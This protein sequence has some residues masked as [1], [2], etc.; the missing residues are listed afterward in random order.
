MHIFGD[1]AKAVFQVQLEL[2]GFP[3]QS[4]MTMVDYTGGEDYVKV[5]KDI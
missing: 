4:I 1:W 2:K 5:F 3:V